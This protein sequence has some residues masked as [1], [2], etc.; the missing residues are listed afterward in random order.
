MNDEE[1]EDDQ[2]LEQVQPAMSEAD[3]EVEDRE[4]MA[5][6]TNKQNRDLTMQVAST[7]MAKGDPIKDNLD[8]PSSNR[9]TGGR[10]TAATS[11]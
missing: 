3:K 8:V 9:D 11:R 1:S 6:F 10:D 7:G 4:S 5:V 2:F